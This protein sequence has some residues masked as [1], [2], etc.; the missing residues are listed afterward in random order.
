M[1][2][3][4][5]TSRRRKITDETFTNE[6]DEQHTHSAYINILFG[7]RRVW[8]S[9]KLAA[10]MRH[11]AACVR[12]IK[13]AQTRKAD[14]A[15]KAYKAGTGTAEAAI[16]AIT[17]RS[18]TCN[19]HERLMTML[20][21]MG[22][23][24]P[25]PREIFWPVFCDCW[26]RCDDTWY[27]QPYLIPAL[28]NHAPAILSEDEQKIF[29][30]LPDRVRVYRGCSRERINGASWTTDRSVAENFARGHRMIPVPDPVVATGIIAKVDIFMTHSRRNE[31]EVL[32]DPDRLQELS[33][34]TFIRKERANHD[35]V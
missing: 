29:D 6:P 12:A 33:V 8:T 24:G 19:S 13:A 20:A 22:R 35:N 34:E 1:I 32:L 21:T 3:A 14:A 26:S 5:T 10:E 18:F 2:D 23:E 25:P 31:D 7:R 15:L 9:R 28:R 30:A 16:E 17:S 4:R 27:L 11:R